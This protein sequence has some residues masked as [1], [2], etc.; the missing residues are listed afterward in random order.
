M[1]KAKKQPEYSPAYVAALCGCVPRTAR[2]WAADNGV[3]FTGEGRRKDYH[4][5]KAD[6]ERFKARPKPGRR[7]G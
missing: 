1:A 5:T 7:W 4:F 2:Q 6:I 3:S